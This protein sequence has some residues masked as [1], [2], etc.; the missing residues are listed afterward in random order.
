VRSSASAGRPIVLAAEQHGHRPVLG[1]RQQVGC[2]LARRHGRPLG[3]PA[4][5]REA[6]HA[7]AVRERGFERVVV[8]DPGDEVARLV[9][10]H[11]DLIRLVRDRPHE[12][13]GARAH[14]LHG[15]DRRRDVDG[16]LRL[17]QDDANLVENGH[18]RS[19]EGG[20]TNG[21]QRAASCRSP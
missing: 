9:R 13:Q 10:H 5:A 2:G 4:P 12:P 14:V 20:R 7:H 19:G 1:V 17:V 16:I 21:R 18:Q 11:L 3:G 15:A 8:L 6:G